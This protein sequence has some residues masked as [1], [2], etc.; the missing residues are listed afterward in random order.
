MGF[1]VQSFFLYCYDVGIHSDYLCGVQTLPLGPTGIIDCAGKCAMIDC[2]CHRHRHCNLVRFA[3]VNKLVMRVVAL[4]EWLTVTIRV[5][6][7]GECETNC[8]AFVEGHFLL[9]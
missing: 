2:H 3:A 7:R 9:C 4:P 6:C 1:L 8:M 5:E